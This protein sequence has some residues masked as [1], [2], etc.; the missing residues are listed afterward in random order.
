MNA[1]V[2]QRLELASALKQALDA[3]ELTVHY[4]PV[5]D[6][7]SRRMLSRTPRAYAAI[8]SALANLI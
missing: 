6:I 8:L 3:D 7:A 4:Q 5:V 2:R 1:Q